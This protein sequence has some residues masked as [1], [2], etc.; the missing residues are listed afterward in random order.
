ML[1]R[2]VALKYDATLHHRVPQAR[3]TSILWSGVLALLLRLRSLHHR[4]GRGKILPIAVFTFHRTLCRCSTGFL[5]RRRRR[6]SS[7]I[8]RLRRS[9]IPRLTTIRTHRGRAWRRRRWYLWLSSHRR[10]LWL[11]PWRVGAT[12]VTPVLR[13]PA[14]PSHARAAVTTSSAVPT[15]RRRASHPDRARRTLHRFSAPRQSHQRRR[16]HHRGATRRNSSTAIH[17]QQ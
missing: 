4:C 17:K 7:R 8:P 14:Q 15:L 2:R 1:S 13:R 3:R 10:R 6:H 16:P 5:C 9:I 12:A 11:P